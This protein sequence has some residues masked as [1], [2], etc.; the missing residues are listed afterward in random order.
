MESKRGGRLW[1]VVVPGVTLIAMLLS[2]TGC[3]GG[4]APHVAL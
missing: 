3:T 2:L 4:A 1:L